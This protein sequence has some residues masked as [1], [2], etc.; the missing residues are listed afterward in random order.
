MRKE[1]QIDEFMDKVSLGKLLLSE[2]AAALLDSPE[3]IAS[4]SSE[5]LLEHEEL[6]RRILS[7]AVCQTK[8]YSVGSDDHIGIAAEESASYE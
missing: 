5:E 4:I 8:G 6:R 3:K 1:E 7:S 2:A